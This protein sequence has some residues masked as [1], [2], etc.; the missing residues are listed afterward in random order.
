[1][2]SVWM[3]TYNHEKFIGKAIESVLS[4]KTNFKIEI[5]IGDDNST[6]N[7]SEI[8]KAYQKQ[9]PNIIKAR[10]N[11]TNKGMM[12]NMIETLNECNGKYVALL[13]GDDYWIYPNKLQ[14]QIDFL[15]SHPEYS[16]SFHNA[17]VLYNSNKKISHIH[18]ILREGDYT[19]NQIISEWLVS[20]ASVVFKNKK[21]HW[22]D[23]TFECAHG[24]ILLFLILLEHGKAYAFNDVWSVYRKNNQNITNS[25]ILNPKYIRRIITQSKNMN[26]Y[27]N[28]KYS[29]SLNNH[30][31]YWHS[32]LLNSYI[33]HKN[34]LSF[35]YGL[36]GFIFSHP[37]HFF[38][39]LILKIK[40]F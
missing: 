19:G 5:V 14:K 7:T 6:D 24:D 10:F 21:I 37:M 25:N 28:K 27:F 9:H 12:P 30:Q 22:P 39:K 15:E 36:L 32:A 17:F 4:Q 11:N 31:I 16:F 29:E 3:I 2:V 40:L 35:G 38:R 33:K 20:T 13:E 26:I 23:F 8:I 34:N 18:A 1:M